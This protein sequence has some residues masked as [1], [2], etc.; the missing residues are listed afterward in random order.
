MILIRKMKKKV[1]QIKNTK[2]QINCNPFVFKP[3][4]SK[5]DKHG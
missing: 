2:Y 5:N 4:K 3:E 1:H